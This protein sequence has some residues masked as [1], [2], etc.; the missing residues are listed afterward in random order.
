MGQ[1][2][3]IYGKKIENEKNYLMGRQVGDFNLG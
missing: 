3:E 1:K 2:L